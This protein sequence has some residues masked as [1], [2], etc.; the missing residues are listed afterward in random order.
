MSAPAQP[1]HETQP[2]DR[3]SYSNL[4]HGLTGRIYLFGEEEQKAY[5]ANRRALFEAYAPASEIEERLV[6]EI[7]DDG[8]R[9][10]RAKTFESA[11]L[12]EHA[13]KFASSG[14]ATG[15]PAVDLALGYA[16]GW[17]AESKNLNLLSL[18]ESRIHRRRDRNTAELRRLQTERKQLLEAAT[19]EAAL[20]THV[21][22]KEGKTCDRSEPFAARGFVFSPEEIHRRVSRFLRLVAANNVLR[23]A[24]PAPRKAA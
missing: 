17:R 12:A 14:E 7:I 13:A 1:I 6:T 22:E 24:I 15:D 5:D 4:R 18:Y 23:A 19:Q 2:R 9:L 8:W 3:R 11:L 20:L 21:A 16:A 10:D